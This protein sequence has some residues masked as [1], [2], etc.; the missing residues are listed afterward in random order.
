MI[1]SENPISIEWNGVEWQ[2]IKE[3]QISRHMTLYGQTL[4]VFEHENN[5]WSR[6]GEK[7]N[8]HKIKNIV[9]WFRICGAMTRISSRITSLWRHND[10]FVTKYASQH[11]VC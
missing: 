7:T 4:G 1:S 5:E 6:N 3:I 2:L 8:Q 9:F 11:H 10:A